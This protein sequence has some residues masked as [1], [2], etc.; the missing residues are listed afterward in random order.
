VSV[1]VPLKNE[2]N[3][4]RGFGFVEFSTKEEAMKAIIAMNG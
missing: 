3:T 4:N 1:N 2:T